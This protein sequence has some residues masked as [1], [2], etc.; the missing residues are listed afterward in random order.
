MGKMLQ[1]FAARV[2][3]ILEPES[4]AHGV[5]SFMRKIQGDAF[6]NNEELAND[7]GAVAEYLWTSGKTHVIVKNRE[8]CSVL[9][10]V[11]RDDVAEEVEAAAIFF[12]S[13]NSRRVHRADHAANIDLQSYPPNGETWRG[14]GFRKEFRGFFTSVKRKK[15]RVPGFLATSADRK[16][17]VSFAFRADNAHP[18]AIW[19][20]TFD[21]RGEQHPEYRVRHMAFVSKTLIKGENEYLFA[22]YSVFKLMSVKWSEEL[23][24]PHEITIRAARDN[25]EEDEDLSVPRCCWDSVATV[26]LGLT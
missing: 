6:K 19:R 12:R 18:C 3:P 21:K 20:I 1:L 24:K 8:L 10:A 17:A 23:K 16:L 11:I 13:I 14:G 4:I 26:L 15:Y 22:P 2:N 9:N 5:H 7:V 25:L